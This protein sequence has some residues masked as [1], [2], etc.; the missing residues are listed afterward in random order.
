MEQSWEQFFEEVK[1]KDYMRRLHNFLAR[2]YQ[3]ATVYPPKSLLLNAFNLTPF[4]QIKVVIIG[5]DPYHEPNQAMGLS[6]S[7]PKSEPLP[8]SLQNIYK[9]MEND[10]GIKMFRNGD[11]TYLAK[12]G[13]PLLNAILSVRKG[14]PLSHQM[15]EY[16]E[17][18][19]DVLRYI[20]LNDQPIVFLLWGSFARK[21]KTYIHNP[22]RLILESVHPSPLSA[23]RGGF[24]GTKPFSKANRY[25][26][27]HGRSP[28]DWQ[29]HE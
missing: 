22:N 20:D 9:E 8:P 23:N 11:L 15:E 2:E 13:V 26:L 27:E 6:F 10:L 25:L 5:Q 1:Q 19:H 16:E 29:N 18:L 17:L 28:I 21:L 24:F 7:V 4:H 14:Q 12:Q 3:T